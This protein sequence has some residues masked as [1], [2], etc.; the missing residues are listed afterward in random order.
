M[1]ELN[2]KNNEYCDSPVA[3]GFD[4][5][6]YRCNCCGKPVA[7]GVLQELANR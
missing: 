5:D 4:G 3:M 1:H 6:V 2:Q 7:P